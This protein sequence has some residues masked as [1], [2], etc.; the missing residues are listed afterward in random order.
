MTARY[1]LALT[2]LPLLVLL[3]AAAMSIAAQQ[4]RITP[5][6][7]KRTATPS[8]YKETVPTGPDRTHVVEQTDVNGNT[9]LVDT[10][11]GLE[12][13]DSTLIKA[14]PPMIYPLWHE[15]IAGINVWDGLMRLTGQKHGI[16]D[17]WGEVSLHNRYFPYAAFGLGA[18]R[19]T[20]DAQNYT[21]RSPVAPFFKLGC[22]YNFL[23][24]SDPSYK[25]LAGLR[26][27][28]SAYSWSLTDVT[29]DEGYWRDPSHFALLNRRSVTGWLEL[30]FGIKVKIVGPLSMGW[31]IHYRSVLHQ[32][33]SPNGAP[34][35]IPGFGYRSTPIGASFSV[36][37]VLPFSKNV[38]QTAAEQV[39]N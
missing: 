17:V 5:V 32:S 3:L 27:G 37:Y 19:V 20:P 16:A 28:F 1:R 38:N 13:V 15:A 10:L 18:C 2:R 4:R 33:S 39:N 23:Y 29:V 11:T 6:T 24:N 25:L 35:Y 14:P 12:F 7:P 34:M 30:T 8:G 36:M 9:V 26:Y 21:F 22:S 31:N